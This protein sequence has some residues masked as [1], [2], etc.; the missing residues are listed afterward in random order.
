MKTQISR[1]SH[2]PDQ[3]YSGVYQQQGRMITDADWNELVDVIKERLERAL[4]EVV[5]SGV[6][7]TSPAPGGGKPLIAGLRIT[8]AGGLQ[9]IPGAVYVHGLRGELIGAGNIAFDAQPDFPGAPL[10]TAGQH[11]YVDL[12]ERTVVS[13]EKNAALRDP[14]LHGADTCTRTQSMVQVKCCPPGTEPTSPDVNPPIGTAR[15]DV[16]WLGNEQTGT[17]GDPCLTETV[18]NARLGNYLFRVEVH[19]VLVVNENEIRLTLKWSSENGAEQHSLPVTTAGGETTVHYDHLSDDF[20][21]GGW[22][23]EI[24]NDASEKHLGK[25]LVDFTPVRGVLFAFK[26]GVTPPEQLNG[27]DGQDR[28][29]Q[30]IRRWDGYCVLKLERTSTQPKWRP[31][32]VEGYDK[33]QQLSTANAGYG[34]V[35]FPETGDRYNM[36]L[37]LERLALTLEIDQHVFLAGDYWL[38]VVREAADYTPAVDH[39]ISVLNGGLP[40]GI[41]HHYLEIAQ[42]DSSGNLNAY[43]DGSEQER[44]LDFPPLTNLTADRIGYDPA[45]QEDRWK[46]INEVGGARS[47]ITVQEAIDGLVNNLESSDIKYTLPACMTTGY[48]APTLKTFLEADIPPDRKFSDGVLTSTKIEDLWHA[49]LCHLDAARLPYNPTRQAVRWA[50]VREARPLATDWVRAFGG[51]KNDYLRGFATDRFGHIILTGAFSTTIDFGGP[52]LEGTGGPDIFLAKLAATGSHIWSRRIGVANDKAG[53]TVFTDKDGNAVL[54]AGFTGSVSLDSFGHLNSTGGSDVLIAKFARNGDCKW[55]QSFGGST[56]ELDYKGAI[57][58][59]GNIVIAGFFSGRIVLGQ[60]RHVSAG[61]HDIFVAKLDGDTGEPLWLHRFGG[62]AYDASYALALDR[63]GAIVL[64]GLFQ[65]TINFDRQTLTSSGQFDI[66]L[67]KLDADGEPIWARGFGGAHSDSAR[68]LAL[69]STG[70]IYLTGSF[71]NEISFGDAAT[72]LTSS[73]GTAVYLAKFTSSGAHLWSRA[74]PGRAKASGHAVTV[75][76]DGTVVLAGNSAGQINLGGDDLPSRGGTDGFLAMFDP[77]GA[78]LHS[79]ALGGDSEDQATYLVAGADNTL[80]LA[81]SFRGN[82]GIADAS[83]TSVGESDIF[84]A[85]FVRPSSGPTTVQDAIDR[86]L[87]DLDSSDLGYAL[88][89]CNGDADTVR[90]RLPTIK[91]LPDGARSTLR[92]VL[93]ALLCE[94]DATTIP[95]QGID[96]GGPSIGELMVKKTGDA[97][98]GPLTINTGSATATALDINGVITTMGFMLATGSPG[99]GWVLSYN[100]TTK[101]SEWRETSLGAWNLSGGNL[102]TNP[103]GVTGSVTIGSPEAESLRVESDGKV[104]IGTHTPAT[105][106]QIVT[107]ADATPSGGYGLPGVWGKHIAD[108]ATQ[109]WGLNNA[110]GRVYTWDSDSLFVGLKDEGSN[111]KDAVIAWGDDPQDSLRFL[112]TESGNPVPAPREHLRITSTGNMGVGT[113]NPLFRIHATDSGGFGGDGAADGT[114]LAGHVPIVAQSNS[115]AIGILN[116]NG[117]QAFALNIDGNLGTTNARG[118]PTFYDKYDGNWH[119]SI[120]LKNGMVG[121]GTSNPTSVLSSGIDTTLQISGSQAPALVLETRPANNAFSDQWAMFS[122]TNFRDLIFRSTTV[123]GS[124]QTSLNCLKISRTTGNVGIGNDTSGDLTFPGA[125]KLDVR[126]RCFSSGGWLTTNADYAEYFEAE[127]GKRIS[128]GTAVVLGREGKI[129]PAKKGE[130]PIGVISARPAFVGNLYKEWP[131]KYVRDELNRLVTEEYQDDVLVPKMEKVRKEREKRQKRKISENVTRIEVVLEDGKYRRKTVTQMVERE[132]EEPVFE[133]MDL[134]DETG[135]TVIGKHRVP[136]M[137]TY[138]EEVPVLDKDGNTRMVPSGKKIKKERHKINPE[139]D[140]KKEYVPRDQRPEWN[141]V[142]LLGQLRLKKGQPV[143]SSWFKIKNVSDDVEL[144]LVK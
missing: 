97:M 10:P 132:V 64:A 34:K 46:D 4:G 70:N 138:E 93:N 52:T 8:D 1:H 128:A 18:D 103:A 21:A 23:Y 92:E 47:P 84:V 37:Q 32:L 96:P 13:I 114:S 43:V 40:L 82:A 106:F 45:G 76:A 24:Y 48:G 119:P 113:V 120:S 2:N 94:L 123:I 95:F 72:R 130:I 9:I 65:G 71:Q 68:G 16:D 29:P 69:D 126:G 62:G 7:R 28:T 42:L 117:R 136:V 11:I 73:G 74:F 78:H 77:D 88:P 53:Q 35:E 100:G 50:D 38:A 108:A 80:L 51:G 116:G 44:R 22:N 139:Y 83:L 124:T 107:V 12:W 60:G 133:E 25:H 17:V 61:A 115:T 33:S 58:S 127:S 59:A 6:P 63:D 105:Q 125:D 41:R 56:G 15:V 86:L 122:S 49:L 144:W 112:F 39:R 99:D 5:G 101:L 109:M 98:T 14:G 19:D 129:R 31:E 3:R 102:S 143:S 79:E 110:Y 55:A 26:D 81:G 134:Y 90:H 131:G 89:S 67:V 54:L 118:V 111:R 140:E 137:E 87:T 27:G 141:C 135:K 20:R 91:N 36:K 85:R 75:M 104:G 121:I 142:G 30:Y 57:D 66:F